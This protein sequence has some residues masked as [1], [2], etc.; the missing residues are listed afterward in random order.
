MAVS[1]EKTFAE[2]TNSPW[3]IGNA[4]LVD[5][6]GQLL[7]AHIAH[8]GLIVFWA[9]TTTI[10][11]VLR[12]NPGI[13]MSEQGMTLLPH[14]ATLGWGV[15]SGG[16]IIDTYPYFVIGMLH[17]VASAVLGAGGLFH[18]FRGPAVLSNPGGQTAKFHY[19][20]YDPKQL[21]LILGHHLLILGLGAFLLVLKAMFFGGIYDANLGEV[22]L[23]DNPTL[24]PKIIF[25]YLVGLKDSGWTALGMA[26]VD[27]LEDVIGGHIWIGIILI[28]GG[29]WH[30][31]VQPFGWVKKIMPIENGY[32]IL[33]YSL[34]GLALM[35]LI[36]SAFVGNNTIVFPPEFYGYD[37]VGS[38]TI[39]LFLSLVAFAGFI[40]H[41]WRFRQTSN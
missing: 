33:S 21:G 30:I 28:I 10:L 14:L 40:W 41:Y 29:A 17:L 15:G 27:N 23:I 18:V 4:R 32:E 13:P 25:G 5:L 34:L 37:R 31:L 20:W 19:E 22:R 7:G 8:A 26:S 11:E 2:G 12:F 35:A 36:S 6:S 38:V 39:Q 3:L 16:E 1:T 9:G 24:D